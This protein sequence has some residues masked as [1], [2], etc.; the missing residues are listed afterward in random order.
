MKTLLLTLFIALH[1]YGDTPKQHSENC[2]Q[3]AQTL[4]SLEEEKSSET[5]ITR[6]LYVIGT[7]IVPNDDK[8]LDENIQLMKLKLAKCRRETP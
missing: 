8:T 5:I 3:I 6:I 7:F 1:L 2:T 4:A